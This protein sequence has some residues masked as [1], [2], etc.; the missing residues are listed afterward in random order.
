MRRSLSMVCRRRSLPQPL[1]STFDRSFQHPRSHCASKSFPAPATLYKK[2]ADQSINQSIKQ[3]NKQSIN[4]S[5]LRLCSPD[6][7]LIRWRCQSTCSQFLDQDSTNSKS[8]TVIFQDLSWK[9]RNQ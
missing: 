7:Q 8:K 6:L 1:S 9:L 2:Q 3:T 5:A 4:Q